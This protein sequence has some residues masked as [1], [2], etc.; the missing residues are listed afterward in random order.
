MKA[1][2]LACCARRRAVEAPT[3]STWADCYSTNMGAP[4]EADVRAALERHRPQPVAALPGRT[5]HLRAGVL[6]PLQWEADDV[7]VVLTLRA[8]HLSTHAGEVCFPG[9]RPEASDRNLEQTAQRE[10][11]EEIGLQEAAVLG[12]LSSVPL[13]TSDYRLEP[14]VARIPSHARLRA[15]PSEVAALLRIGI[16]EVLRRST[17][18]A[19]PWEHEGRRRLSPVF[20]VED[21][22]VF[23]GTAHVLW[24]LV[25]ILA[26][27][28]GRHLPALR[29]G[30]Y[31]W[32]DLLPG[33]RTTNP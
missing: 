13:Y 33:A 11:R 5:N 22:V 16:G 18:D 19:I 9:G 15:E 32:S 24:E 10:S 21:H 6:V 29:P 4:S 1:E 23:G 30:R 27:V 17:I 25:Q 7:R 28:W 31:Q 26:P 8:A 14:F 12:R 2:Q 20:E 3:A